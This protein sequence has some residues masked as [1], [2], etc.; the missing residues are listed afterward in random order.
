[1]KNSQKKTR[2]AYFMVKKEKKAQNTA[3]GISKETRD[4]LKALALTKSYHYMNNYLD[5]LVQEHIQLLS[6]SDYA[7]YRTFLRHINPKNEY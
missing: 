1:M 3:I 7:D 6:A 2:M 5:D 4:K